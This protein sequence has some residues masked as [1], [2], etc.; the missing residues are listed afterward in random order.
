MV[1]D[2]LTALRTSPKNGKAKP[3]FV[4]S[5]DGVDFEAEELATGEVI[6]CK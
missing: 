2:T 1:G 6:A 4:L 3:K 5:T